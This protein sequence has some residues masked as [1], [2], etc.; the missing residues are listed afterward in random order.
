MKL[1][2]IFCTYVGAVVIPAGV[3]FTQISSAAAE[4][5]NEIFKRVNQFVQAKNYSKALE[6]LGWAKKEIEKLN[7][8]QLESFFPESLNG[9]K[10][11]QISSSNALG[12]TNIER[13]YKKD[14]STSFK[15]SLTGGGG[16][17][18]LPGGM[19]GL[20]A[21]GKMAAMMGNEGTDTVRISGKTAQLEEHQDQKRADLTIFLD[22]GSILK[23]EGTN[24][25]GGA[26]RQLAEALK[27][28]D[29]DTYL[30]GGA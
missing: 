19:G 11:Q 18:G 24:L 20:A 29:L 10:G 7:S 6:E 12:I 26:L 25:D 8:K 14:E 15:V 17:G 4:D 21:F 1:S 28:G 13:L 16:P 3:F 2:K 5:I 30:K 22:S 27:L 9:F 23:L